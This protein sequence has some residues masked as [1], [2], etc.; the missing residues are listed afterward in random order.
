MP[1]KKQIPH[2]ADSVRNEGVAFRQGTVFHDPVDRV[3]V[4]NVDDRVLVE[5]HH[6][7]QLARLERPP[8]E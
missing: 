2:S 6:I 1:R 3:G 4:V 5:D 7:R 8:N